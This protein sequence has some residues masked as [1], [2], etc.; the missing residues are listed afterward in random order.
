[1]SSNGF[2][3]I[4]S[5]FKTARHLWGRCPNCDSVFRL[6]D[7]AISSNPKPPRDWLTKL[8]RQEAN[9]ALQEQDLMV[10][11]DE[12][13]GREDDLRDGEWELQRG[14]RNLERDSKI[15]VREILG[16]ETEIKKLIKLERKAAVK[17]SRSTLIGRLMER[18]AP[19]LQRFGYS[20]LDMRTICDPVDYVVFDGLTVE[21]RVKRITFVEVKCGRSV[22]SPAQ[23]SIVEAV[24][25]GRVETE[26]WEI[27]EHGI[28][29]AQQFSR[30]SRFA[31]P[32][33]ED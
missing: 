2:K 6:S 20:P 29:I 19:C 4:V 24:D 12:I 16:S 33:D 1:M 15:R 28:P 21:R 13:R 10:Q 11:D 5:F 7:A 22:L 18:M 9:L 23:R 25:K 31:L 3:E 17:T 8:K 30:P 26:V 14:Q 32:P 27:G